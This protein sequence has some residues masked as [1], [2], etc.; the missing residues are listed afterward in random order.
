MK[1]K[2]K[3]IMA[4]AVI[5]T[6]GIGGTLAYL[7]H[8]TDK[9]VNTFASNKNI[10]MEM[11]ESLWDGY[12]FGEEYPGVPGTIP[13]S[14]DPGLG[15]NIAKNY[16]PGDVIPKNPM[17][18]NT[19]LANSVSIYTAVKVQY[20]EYSDGIREKISYSDFKQK[21][22]TDYGIEFHNE[23]AKIEDNG[24]QGQIYLYGAIGTNPQSQVFTT[25]YKL[26]PGYTTPALFAKVPLSLALEPDDEGVLPK[27]YIELTAYGI[28][29]D[30]ISSVD[31]AAKE[32]LILAA[33]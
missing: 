28:Q 17:V 19:G 25:A 29:I 8:T 22:L 4:I 11:R 5:A 9:A 31:Q 23:W 3:I 33:K 14:N 1:R 12:E 26:L 30:N 21:F 15:L 6:L 13:K 7:N 2:M 27:F 18:K 20:Y 32:L 16:A 24:N 10:K